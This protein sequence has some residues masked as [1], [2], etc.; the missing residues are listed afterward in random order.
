MDTENPVFPAGF[1]NDTH[2]V[3]VQIGYRNDVQRDQAASI[4]KFM[5]GSLFIPYVNVLQDGNRP[6][7]FKYELYNWV[8]H[9]HHEDHVTRDQLK[10]MG[11]NSGYTTLSKCSFE[12]AGPAYNEVGMDIYSARMRPLH[13]LVEARVSEIMSM[14]FTTDYTPHYLK[15]TPFSYCFLQF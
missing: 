4:G 13:G 11:A 7:A 6:Y 1:P 15:Y 9:A 8:G 3:I 2:P 14:D 12:P 5:I 10:Y